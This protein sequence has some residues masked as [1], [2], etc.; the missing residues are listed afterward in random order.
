MP[1][2]RDHRGVRDI[3]IG[4]IWVCLCCAL[5][6]NNGECC[7][8]TEHGGD[9][10]APWSDVDGRYTVADASG[11]DGEPDAF[12]SAQCEGCGSWLAGERHLFFMWRTRRTYR[13][14]NLPA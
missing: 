2:L 7:A 1:T 9:S 11:P 6:H 14:P 3:E 10:I 8:D 12:S 13:R 5:S 4:E